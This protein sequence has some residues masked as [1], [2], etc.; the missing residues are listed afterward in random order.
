MSRRDYGFRF[1]G[2]S[3]FARIQ[4]DAPQPSNQQ[5]DDDVFVY[6]MGP[7]TAFDATYVYVVVGNLV[8]NTSLILSIQP[9]CCRSEIEQ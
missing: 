5:L 7:Y 1:E 9:N 3:V 2:E 6:V 8:L 4:Q